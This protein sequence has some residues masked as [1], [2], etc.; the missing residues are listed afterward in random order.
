MIPLKSVPIVNKMHT[1]NAQFIQGNSTAFPT[2]TV[3]WSS[4]CKTLLIPELY[5]RFFLPRLQHSVLLLSL[6]C[7]SVSI[8]ESHIV[9][10]DSRMDTKESA[11]TG[12]NSGK[13]DQIPSDF[14]A[15]SGRSRLR[16]TYRR[17][18]ACRASSA[19]RRVV[20]GWIPPCT[21]SAFM[22]ALN[23]V[24]TLLPAMLKTSLLSS[25]VSSG[26][27]PSF[28]SFLSRA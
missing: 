9:M 4:I 27:R 17:Q 11:R 6:A 13:V 23:W 26:F 28:S 10:G 12:A 19:S 1:I 20:P 22:L 7:L 18:P 2:S 16:R 8:R 15:P 24:I 5:G 21:R 3:E 14:A 25:L